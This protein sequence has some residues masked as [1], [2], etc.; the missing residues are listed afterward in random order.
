MIGLA[1]TFGIEVLPMWIIETKSMFAALRSA[2]NCDS[3]S[4]KYD[5]QRLLY[6][7]IVISILNINE[8]DDD[9]LKVVWF[10]A[11]K[12]CFAGCMG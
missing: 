10:A 3:I 9:A 11:V 7:R 6:G 1:L 4:S 2:H 12:E 8:E 5:G